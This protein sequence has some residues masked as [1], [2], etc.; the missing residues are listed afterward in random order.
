MLLKELFLLSLLIMIPREAKGDGQVTSNEKAKRT[1][2][3]EIWNWGGYIPALKNLKRELC[4]ER[5]IVN[6][7]LIHN[8]VED[9]KVEVEPDKKNQMSKQGND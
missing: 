9:E 2:S 5:E 4:I 6:M 1:Q 3:G 8:Q 7:T